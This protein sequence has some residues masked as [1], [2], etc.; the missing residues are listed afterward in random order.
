M[1]DSSLLLLFG[2]FVK[3]Y[4][5]LG[6]YRSPLVRLRG[7]SR[8]SYVLKKDHKDMSRIQLRSFGQKGCEDFLC[9]PAGAKMV[10][11][12]DPFNKVKIDVVYE[13]DF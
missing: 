5:G 11:F 4:P 10:A 3:T 2:R 12:V 7:R 1:L 8:I 6:S 13:E 9:W